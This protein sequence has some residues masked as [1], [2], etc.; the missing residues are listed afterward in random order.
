MPTLREKKPDRDKGEGETPKCPSLHA[1]WK[2]NLIILPIIKFYPN[3]FLFPFHH[4][5]FVGDL[6]SHAVKY[7]LSIDGVQV[8][9]ECLEFRKTKETGQED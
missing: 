4:C 3:F 9:E 6:H 7:D 5:H 2:A 1:V 8:C